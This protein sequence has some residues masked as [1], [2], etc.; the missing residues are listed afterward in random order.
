[1]NKTAK[2]LLA[3]LLIVFI[4]A[5]GAMI[6]SAHAA[7]GTTNTEGKLETVLSRMSNNGLRITALSLADV[8]GPDWVAAAMI[9]PGEDE[10]SIKDNYGV[11][12]AQLHLKGTKV[13]DDVNYIVMANKEGGFTFEQFDRVEVDVCSTPVQ[14]G[15]DTRQLVP[16]IKQENG[17]WA[18]AS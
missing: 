17:G 18:I 6:A 1:M 14:G 8:Y 5:V 2:G 9:C 3:T 11:D 15:F 4:A 13:P 12:P 16:F 10:K 7:V